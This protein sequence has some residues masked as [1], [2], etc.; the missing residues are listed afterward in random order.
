M[1]L[2]KLKDGVSGPIVGR[3]SCIPIV[4]DLRTRRRLRRKRW[5]NLHF[6]FYDQDGD[7]DPRAESI[8]FATARIMPR[9]RPSSIRHD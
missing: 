2:G 5:P 6:D 4:A 7:S 9:S 1:R 3:Q 8:C